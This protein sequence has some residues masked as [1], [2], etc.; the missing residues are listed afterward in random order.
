MSCFNG[1]A[2][3]AVAL[4]AAVS[5][6][7]CAITDAGALPAGSVPTTTLSATK[8][9]LNECGF[10]LISEPGTFTLTCADAGQTL[11][12]LVWADWGSAEAS[13][14]GREVVNLCTPNCAAGK[15]ASFSVSVI[16]SQL[17]AGRSASA[18]TRLSVT[19]QGEVP[20]G[21]RSREVFTLD[22]PDIRHTSGR[23]QSSTAT[24]PSGLAAP[25]SGSRADCSRQKCIALTFDDG[26]GPYTRRLLGYLH[27]AGVT[28]TFF[29]V[30]QQV[31]ARPAVAKAVNAGGNE[32]GVHTWDH[33]D[34]T[35]LTP[36]RVD[37]EL[38]STIRVIRSDTGFQPSLLRPP[39]G[40]MDATVH[41]AARK[42]G[43]AIAMWSVDT[44]DWKT[45][46]TSRTVAAALQG[47]RRGAIIL[48]HDTHPWSVA[49]VPAI[50]KGLRSRGYTLVTVSTLLGHQEAGR[51]YRRG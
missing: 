44:L 23:R 6:T 10:D 31:A 13:A 12:G 47:A 7:G 33:P 26:P 27:S 24:A 8:V 45:R 28:A 18:Y 11:Q 19:G 4:V 50:L 9:Y 17:T 37:T 30:G 34:L 25:A 49:A 46:S 3:S 5:L 20:H 43:L 35:R 2:A 38:S 40:A 48:V 22:S 1:I 14:T 39:Y 42:F 21:L 51:A 16:A 41:S 29:M 32:I 15:V 36:A